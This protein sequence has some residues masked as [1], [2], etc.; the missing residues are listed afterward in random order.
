MPHSYAVQLLA[1]AAILAKLAG[2]AE[3]GV[4]DVA[5]NASLFLDARASAKALADVEG[6]EPAREGRSEYMR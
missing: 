2:R 1:P 3:I 4:E 6:A 5:E